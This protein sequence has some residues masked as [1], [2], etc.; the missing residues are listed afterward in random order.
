LDRRH[1][2][3]IATTYDLPFF[4][5]AGWALKNALGNWQL[6]QVYTFQSPEY[7]TVQSGADTNLN[8][9]TAGDRAIFNPAGVPGTGSDVTPL[10]T[11][12]LPTGVD[13]GSSDSRPFL[14]GYAAVNPNAQYIV[15]GPGSRATISR[16]TLAL[17]HVN[18]WDFGLMKR[19]TL[20]ERQSLQF[21]FQATNLFNHA[22][23]LPGNI[24]DVSPLT[25]ISFTG[26]NVLATLEP[27]SPSFNKPQSVWSN[28]PRNV[29]LVLKYNF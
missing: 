18:N 1:R 26:A 27:N 9:D 23:Y 20:T 28:H 21:Q 29:V 11:S 25:N 14:V 24:S 19:I 12:A 16:N 8:G 10:C 6:S 22:Q 3:T 15:A 17:P 13:C 5:N 2:L 4:K 7:A